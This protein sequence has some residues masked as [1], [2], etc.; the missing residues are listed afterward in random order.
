MVAV[1]VLCFL[2]FGTHEETY[3]ALYA[4]GVFILLSL[5]G[6]ATVKRLLREN[7]RGPTLGGLATLGGVMLAALLTSGA[8]K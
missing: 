2:V 7:R 5:T 3:L 4:A 8:T 1:C 6:W